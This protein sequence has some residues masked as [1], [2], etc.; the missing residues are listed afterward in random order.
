MDEKNYI[1]N[2]PPDVPDLYVNSFAVN[3]GVYDF[4]IDMGLSNPDNSI[5]PL[6]RLRMSPQYAWVMCQLLTKA[7]ESYQKTVGEIKVS[8]DMLKDLGLVEVQE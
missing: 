6:V 1:W 2:I 5:K 8:L 7:I 4:V 3:T